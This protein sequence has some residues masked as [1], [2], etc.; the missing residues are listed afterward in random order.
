MKIKHR[1]FLPILLKWVK[2]RGWGRVCSAGA[3]GGSDE[4]KVWKRFLSQAPSRPHAA[5]LLLKAKDRSPGRP[6]WALAA[7]RIGKWS[8]QFSGQGGRQ[9]GQPGGREILGTL[10]KSGNLGP[11]QG[12][13]GASSAVCNVQMATAACSPKDAWVNDNEKVYVPVLKSPPHHNGE[14]SS[15]ASLHLTCKPSLKNTLEP[16]LRTTWSDGCP[17]ITGPARLDRLISWLKLTSDQENVSS[18]A[19]V[20]KKTSAQ[21][22]NDCCLKWLLICQHVYWSFFIYFF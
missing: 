16:K 8:E 15:S 3:G 12:G 21:L 6:G 17:C 9:D 2:G 14:F 10:Q 13:L 19:F 4:V 20:S 18:A 7:P 22:T 11:A 5:V 1:N